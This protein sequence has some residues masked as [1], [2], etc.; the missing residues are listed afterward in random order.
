MFATRQECISTPSSGSFA[1][2]F[3]DGHGAWLK[4]EGMASGGSSGGPVVT[5]DGSVIGW[6]VR[7]VPT[8]PYAGSGIQHLRPIEAADECIHAASERRGVDEV[9][10][11]AV[12]VVVAAAAAAA[13]EAAAAAA[14][15]AAAVGFEAHVFA[16]PHGGRWERPCARAR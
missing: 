15:A 7:Q 16:W 11:A 1:E 3:R 2:C 4:Y 5:A 6:V 9:H 13:A 8:I 14:A 12:V 10:T